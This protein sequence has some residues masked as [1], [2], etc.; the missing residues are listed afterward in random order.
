MKNNSKIIWFHRSH[1]LI[2]IYT[3][4]GQM[5]KSMHHAP[6]PSPNKTKMLE[7]L[8]ANKS[9]SYGVG[10]LCVKEVSLD[11]DVEDLIYTGA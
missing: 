7:E 9:F 4:P 1:G 3:S 8:K 6:Y 11:T 10:Q 5:L 2:G